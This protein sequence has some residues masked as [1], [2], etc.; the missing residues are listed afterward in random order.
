MKRS[1]MRRG[2]GRLWSSLVFGIVG[3]CTPDRL[4][5]VDPPSG[6]VD[7]T[8]VATAAGATQLANYAINNFALIFGGAGIMCGNNFLHETGLITDELM[9]P[10]TGGGGN[11]SSY[12]TRGWNGIQDLSPYRC[13][14][15]D[16]PLYNQP[17][18][19]ARQ[20]REALALYAP[21]TSMA[22]QGRLYSLEAYTILMLAE[23][24]CSG[25]PLSTVTFQGV[26]TP[27]PGFTTDELFAHAAALF[28][29]AATIGTDSAR[30]VNFAKVGKARALLQLGKFADAAAAVRGVPT[31]F[32]Y[33]ADYGTPNVNFRG[34]TPRSGFTQDNE[35]TNGLIWSTDPRT[36][37]VATPTLSAT[38]PYSAK[39]SRTSTGVLDPTQTIANN[40]IWLA[41]GVEARLIEA[42]ADLAA[43]GS[44][45]LPTL[46]LLRSTCIGTAAC[47]PVPGLTAVSLPPL[48]DPGNADAGLNLVMR[49]RAMWLFLTGHRQGDFRRLVR[50]YHRA[51]ET[52][53]P[54]GAYVNPGF[55]PLINASAQNGTAYGN[56]VVFS[57]EGTSSEAASNPLYN[58]CFNYDP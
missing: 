48:A 13:S 18:I 4:V 6:V 49:E 30:F 55:A 43:G 47:A 44:N 38:M 25:I 58:G 2:I 41:S 23:L 29:T 16:Y 37:I 36:A 20:A 24:Y 27:T 46:N 5:K 9:W 3:A 28:D 26:T 12:D 35:G 11:A 39:Y 50:V 14:S 31:D 42:E 21:T 17:R 34:N 7:P 53:W 8:V 33:T 22:W 56:A 51:T 57:P 15:G 45:W 1:M 40:P 32:V 10:A 19:E 54:T 52:V